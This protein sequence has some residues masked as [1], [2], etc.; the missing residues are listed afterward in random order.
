MDLSKA[1]L[2]EIMEVVTANHSDG[3]S[4]AFD[5]WDSYGTP[6]LTASAQ[7]RAWESLQKNPL[8]S[9]EI[10]ALALQQAMQLEPSALERG[11]E[12]V[13]ASIRH[14]LP[15]LRFTPEI[16][17]GPDNPRLV[18]QPGVIDIILRALKLNN[19]K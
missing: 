14:S 11:G 15:P 17:Q 19:V 13:P 6:K 10:E 2:Q 1:T 8:Y 9:P 3:G 16:S 12:G 18:N 4:L 7:K 5:G